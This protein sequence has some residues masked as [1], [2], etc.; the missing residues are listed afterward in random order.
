MHE[1]AGLWRASSS[2][3]FTCCLLRGVLAHGRRAALINR[4]LSRLYTALSFTR[5]A[6]A[7]SWLVGCL[8]FS[9][10]KK[11]RKN[12]LQSIAWPARLCLYVLCCV[13]VRVVG[14]CVHV[15]WFIQDY[16]ISSAVVVFILLLINWSTYSILA[17]HVFTFYGYFSL[18]T[19]LL[20]TH[21]GK[22]FS[23]FSFIPNPT[24]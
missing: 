19:G 9:W 23:T 13:C 8:V 15:G 24:W 12:Q 18:K 3:Q 16:F 14:A 1:P 11:S 20:I 21:F 4:F 6:L 10:T 5:L 7:V 17:D 22:H 2:I